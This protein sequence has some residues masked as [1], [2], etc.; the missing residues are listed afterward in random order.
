[1]ANVATVSFK[2]SPE[3]YAILKGM[4]KAEGVTVSEL[5]RRTLEEALDLERQ[6]ALLVR[7]LAERRRRSEAG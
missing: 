1:M 3:Q 7:I 2:V 5:V 4:A 6:V